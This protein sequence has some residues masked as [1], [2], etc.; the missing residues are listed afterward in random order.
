MTNVGNMKDAV[1]RQEPPID[2]QRKIRT[3][4][5]GFESLR[6][7]G[8]AVEQQIIRLEIDQCKQCNF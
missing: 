3:M 7:I 2:E 1:P 5:Q 4:A 6:Y 8:W